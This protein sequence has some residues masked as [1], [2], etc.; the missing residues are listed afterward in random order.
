MR[1]QVRAFARTRELLGSG[2]IDL[3]LPA[4]S[5]VADA[6]IALEARSPLLRDLAASTRLARNARIVKREDALAD[7]DELALLPPVGGG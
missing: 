5:T 6:W 3:E 2:S 1:I 4:G 7:G